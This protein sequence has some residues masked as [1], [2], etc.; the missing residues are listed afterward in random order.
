MYVEGA[1]RAGGG[2]GAEGEGR[3]VRVGTPRR[4]GGGIFLWTFQESGLQMLQSFWSS[5]CE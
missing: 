1:G 3:G 4:G 2:G 5:F